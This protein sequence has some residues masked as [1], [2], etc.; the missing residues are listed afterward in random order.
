VTRAPATR[1]RGSR[2][3]APAAVV[4][5]RGTPAIDDAP[6]A[7]KP[8]DGAPVDQTR[9][10][11]TPASRT[12]P[13]APPLL[14][15]DFDPARYAAT[16]P[17]TL[18]GLDP[19][20]LARDY[21]AHGAAGGRA[22]SAITSRAAFLALLPSPGPVLEVGPF[23][24]PWP[25]PAGTV[26]RYLDI[27]PTEALRTT[28][29]ALPWGDA[30]R[31]PDIDYVWRGEPYRDLIRTRFPAI[32]S[33]HCIEHQPCLVTHL[34]DLASV[35]APGGRVFLVVPDH[36]YAFDHFVPTSTLVDV[37]DA[38]AARRGGH[39]PRSTIAH[40]LLKTHNDP[41]AHWAGAHGPDPWTEAGLVGRVSEA[42]R[43]LRRTD[44]VFDLHA[45]QFTPASFRALFDLMAVA[46]LSPFRIERLYPT[47]RDSGE[48]YAVLRIAA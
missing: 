24:T 33:S 48:F 8:I 4:A 10:D 15:P 47:L 14:P 27:M 32:L 7:P 20:A 6:A 12:P 18:G 9:I 16:D 11:Q 31:V 1:S 38:Y 23:C 29:A 21:A 46:G 13:P 3:P 36:R 45:W 35:L 42:L 44:L 25:A 22:C 37:L 19:A 26:V 43:E 28:A 39:A 30:S 17:T 34:T 41:P 2:S 40:N 5:G